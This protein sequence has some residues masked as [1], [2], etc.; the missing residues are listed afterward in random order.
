MRNPP[1][2]VELW[3]RL[4]VGFGG[5]IRVRVYRVDGALF[6]AG[7]GGRH[8]AECE[9]LT[10]LVEGL[11]PPGP[12]VVVFQRAGKHWRVRAS[13]SLQE[14][15]FEQRLRNTLVNDPWGTLPKL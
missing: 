2:H 13:A 7:V 12:G 9:R 1:W 3:D 10:R 14:D 5:G 6:L 4:C 11:E 8:P 15:G